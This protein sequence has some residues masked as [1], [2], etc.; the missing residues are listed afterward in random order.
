MIR[1]CS[2][3][4]KIFGIKRPWFCFSIT[5]GICKKCFKKLAKLLEVSNED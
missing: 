1:K 5:H 4:G 2:Y 3:C